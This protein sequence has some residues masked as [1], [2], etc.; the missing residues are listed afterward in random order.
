[1]ST[2]L[3]TNEEKS[4]DDDMEDVK[5]RKRLSISVPSGL[6]FWHARRREQRD[7]EIE[8]N[9]IVVVEKAEEKVVV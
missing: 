1:M 7:T 5:K 3:E 9:S 4:G 6:R 8:M 2:T